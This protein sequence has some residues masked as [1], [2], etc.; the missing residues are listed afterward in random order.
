MIVIFISFRISDLI[1]SAT[2]YT[3]DKDM[4]TGQREFI[5]NTFYFN[6][7]KDHNFFNSFFQLLNY[8]ILI[9]IILITPNLTSPDLL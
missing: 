6:D 3:A 4:T 7:S 2:V 9:S 5:F 8:H 1:H